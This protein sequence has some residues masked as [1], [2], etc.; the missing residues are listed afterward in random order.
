[1]PPTTD[2]LGRPLRD[3]RISVTDRCNFRCPYCMPAE[4]Y[5]EKYHFLPRPELLSF[6]EIE[7]LARLF[8]DL[9][10]AKIRITGGEPLLRH[11]LPGLIERLAALRGVRDLALTSNGALLAEQAKS[12]AD[13]G[14]SRVTVSLDSHDAAVFRR[15]SGRDASPSAVLEGIE[16]AEAVGLGPVKINCVVMRGVN[17]DG[18]VEL[19]RRMRGTGRI[20]RFIEYMDVGTLNDWDVARVVTAKEIVERIDAALPL[21]PAEPNYRGEVARRYVY[22]DGGG[23]IGVIASV[24]QPFCGDC[25]RARLTT[26]GKLVT[27]LFASDGVDLRAP[28]RAGESDAALLERIAG[29]WSRRSDRYSEERTAHTEL[30]GRALRRRKLEMYQVG[31]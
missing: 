22:R 8:V 2:Q 28:L 1:M 20:L 3:L 24:S 27:C 4:I 21:V 10:V 14:L 13:A 15:M 5:G 6:E 17:D 12:L 26:E 19:A 7:R 23:E 18:L 11:Q 25:T 30:P 16:A 31:G 9:G 29:V